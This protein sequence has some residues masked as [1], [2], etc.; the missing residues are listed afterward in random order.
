MPFNSDYYD[1]Y[2]SYNVKNNDNQRQAHSLK[3]I[4]HSSADEFDNILVPDP[5]LKHFKTLQPVSGSANGVINLVDMC[6]ERPA[7]S[8]VV[9]DYFQTLTMYSKSR[10]G[11]L[12][13]HTLQTPLGREMVMKQ[14]TNVLWARC[15]PG[16]GSLQEVWFLFWEI[17]EA[18]NA[19]SPD[20]NL[21]RL[22][23]QRMAC[24]IFQEVVHD[25]EDQVIEY[26]RN[27]ISGQKNISPRK[28]ETNMEMEAR[29]YYEAFPTND[30]ETYDRINKLFGRFLTA[31]E[32]ETDAIKMGINQAWAHPWKDKPGYEKTKD[33]VQK[34]LK[35]LR[36]AFKDTHP[37]DINIQRSM[38]GLLGLSA[39]LQL[40]FP[41]VKD[42]ILLKIFY[43]E[44]LNHMETDP[45]LMRDYVCNLLNRVAFKTQTSATRDVA[46]APA[47]HLPIGSD[48][49]SEGSA[50][51]VINTR[52]VWLRAEGGTPTPFTL[53]QAGTLNLDAVEA[54]LGVR[55]RYL[56][57]SAGFVFCAEMPPSGGA[58]D[59]RTAPLRGSRLGSKISQTYPAAPLVSKAVVNLNDLSVSAMDTHLAMSSG[60]ELEASV[61]QWEAMGS[62]T[63]VKK[64][65]VF[66]DT[67]AH[68]NIRT[69]RDV[70]RLTDEE[71][72]RL[73]LP[74][75]LRNFLRTTALTYM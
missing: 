53:D 22:M 61:V 9:R 73:P 14:F 54:V 68:Q 1:Y 71:W 8:L 37:K 62:R 3:V 69:W 12:T 25:R 36:E 10:Q 38:Y 34:R 60:N 47:P 16:V 21:L 6:T 67:L 52:V 7:L 29:T 18:L 24:H 57:D 13:D 35:L 72:A 27:G 50:G 40:D 64:C 15:M 20:P 75:G 66:M 33:L 30:E 19:L 5:P 46:C 2:K 28:Q 11:T 70:N 42:E 26:F 74:I 45:K 49:S 55:P 41:E 59:V 56:Q 4:F 63:Q 23:C 58:Y 48:E 32:I 39:I 17:Q 43:A 31:Q 44:F 51:R 65:K